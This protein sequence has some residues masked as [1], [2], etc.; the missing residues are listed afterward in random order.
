MQGIGSAWGCLERVG[1]MRGLE[2]RFMA[3]GLS[4]VAVVVR[5]G[6]G[7]EGCG[8]GEGGEE[9]AD[10]E[11]RGRVV[12]GVGFLVGWGEETVMVCI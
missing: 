2:G 5:L 3:R 8:R 11:E 1:G 12:L 10:L 4:G 7:L 6:G 9:G